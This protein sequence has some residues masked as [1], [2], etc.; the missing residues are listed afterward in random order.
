MLKEAKVLNFDV[1]NSPFD[2]SCPMNTANLSKKIINAIIVK[3]LPETTT[4]RKP[5]IPLWRV[6]K[7]I[8]HRLKTDCQ[9]RELPVRAFCRDKLITWQ[10]VY[11]H[12]NKWSKLGVWKKIWTALLK[13][14]K[15]RNC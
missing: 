8:I 4:G 13:A 7:M 9:W 5:T 2:N 10:S 1:K 14:N 15:N 12:F 11:Y 3:Y 6:V